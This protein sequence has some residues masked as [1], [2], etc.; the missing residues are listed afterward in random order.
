M[1]PFAGYAFAMCGDVSVGVENGGFCFDLR[2]ILL[3][4]Y[5]VPFFQIN[6]TDTVSNQSD[7]YRNQRLY[8]PNNARA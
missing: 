2:N 6:A 4:G 5:T 7:V 8:L 1:L 3:G